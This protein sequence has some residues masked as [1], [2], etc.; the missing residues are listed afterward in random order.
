MKE[1]AREQKR[2]LLSDNK[3]EILAF[4]KKNNIAVSSDDRIFW[5]SMHK[6]R[7]VINGIPEDKKEESRQWL[8]KN[9]FSPEIRPVDPITAREILGKKI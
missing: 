5:A 9:G 4:A 1:L 6:A 2:V 7:L 3:E 8:I